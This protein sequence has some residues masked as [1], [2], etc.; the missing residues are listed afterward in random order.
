MIFYALCRDGRTLMPRK[1]AILCKLRAHGF[2]KLSPVLGT[3]GIYRAT[4]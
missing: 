1:R 4:E 3:F 2:E